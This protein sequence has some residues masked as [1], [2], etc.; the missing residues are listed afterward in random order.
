LYDL[1]CTR[2]AGAIRSS[3]ARPFSKSQRPS[4]R[5]VIPVGCSGTSWNG[6]PSRRRFNQNASP[7]T[8]YVDDVHSQNRNG[9]IAGF[10]F[11]NNSA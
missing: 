6:T 9:E 11:R 7:N 10:G 1:K 4:S 8:S 3:R 2:S 5:N